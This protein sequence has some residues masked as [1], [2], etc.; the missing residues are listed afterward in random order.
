VTILC[1]AGVET[2]DATAESSAFLFLSP[3]VSGIGKRRS[4]NLMMVENNMR[5]FGETVSFNCF[6]VLR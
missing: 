2:G 4:K 5:H 1:A 3:L 6:L